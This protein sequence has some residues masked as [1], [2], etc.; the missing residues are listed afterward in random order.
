MDKISLKQK[1]NSKFDEI[2][3][4]ISSTKQEVRN[5]INRIFDNLKK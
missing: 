2:L 4:S 1:I 5:F 3:F